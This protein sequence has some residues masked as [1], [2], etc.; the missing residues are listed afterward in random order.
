MKK[1]LVWTILLLLIAFGAWWFFAVRGTGKSI[2]QAAREVSFPLVG[3]VM[4]RITGSGNGYNPDSEGLSPDGGVLPATKSPQERL[5]QIVPTPIAGYTVFTAQKLLANVTDV[6]TKTA[7]SPGSAVTPIVT[8]TTTKTDFS[9]NKYIRYVDRGNGYVYEIANDATPIQISNITIPNIYEAFFADTGK[10][11]FLRFLRD[12]QK[13]IATFA[14]PIP[15]ANIDGSRSQLSGSFLPDNIQSFAVSPDTKLLAMLAPN[16]AG[17]SVLTVADTNN[18]SR[19]DI[20]NN[21]FR[22]WLISWTNQ[23]RVNVQTKA[24]G[25][26]E[27]YFYGILQADVRLKK[28]VG[29]VLGLTASVSPKGGYVL[30]SESTQNGFLTKVLNTNTQKTTTLAIRSLPEKCTWTS[31]EDLLCA[32]TPDLPKAVYPDGWYAGLVHFNDSLVRINP[33][34]GFLSTLYDGTQDF[35]AIMLQFDEENNQLYFIN[36]NDSSLWRLNM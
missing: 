34:S 8:T 32:V 35:D 30:Y 26:V 14:V 20:M 17:G 1:F 28:A 27:G 33:N 16:G 18:R 6:S 29:G 10:K 23:D 5:E 19:K 25:T 11:V 13:T 3:N 36:K 4:N 2:P 24:A 22:D 31:N 21:T 12:D 15:D 7:T 9:T